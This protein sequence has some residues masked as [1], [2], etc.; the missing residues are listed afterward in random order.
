MIDRVLKAAKQ[1]SNTRD[2]LAILSTFLM[3]CAYL[4]PWFVS[5]PAANTNAAELI[6]QMQGAVILQWGGV[7]SWYFGSSKDSA[8]KTETAAVQAATI[9]AMAPKDGAQ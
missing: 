5:P 4:L 7:M 3:A 1:G 6:S 2:A 9:A 8:A